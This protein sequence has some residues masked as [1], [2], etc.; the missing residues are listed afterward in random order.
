MHRKPP[1]LVG[2]PSLTRHLIL[3]ETQ[4]EDP[5]NRGRPTPTFRREKTIVIDHY[6]ETLY[7]HLLRK[8]YDVE[9]LLSDDESLLP[10]FGVIIQKATRRPNDADNEV[11]IFSF[12]WLNTVPTTM[13]FELHGEYITISIVIDMSTTLS[14]DARVS[15]N[16]RRLLRLLISVFQRLYSLCLL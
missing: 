15:R 10:L 16:G 3:W 6:L 9:T 1:T 8:I 11:V 4:Q 13:R 14:P 5:A 2:V 12:N 7:N